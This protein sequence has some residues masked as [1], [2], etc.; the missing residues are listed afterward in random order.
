M[1]SESQAAHC[2][3]PPEDRLNIF[4]LVI[5]LPD[6]LGSFLDDLRRELVPHD[7]PHA[8]V[9][10]LPPRPL[11]VDW[12]Q[13]S[14]QVRALARTWKPFDVE[15]T[16]IGIFPVTNVIYIEIGEGETELRQMHAATNQEALAFEEP[17]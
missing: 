12:P 17:F 4:A 7:N 16:R 5:Y 8:H 1:A 14:E 10:V 6:P 11:A 3:V 15:L 2:R 13:A 9:S